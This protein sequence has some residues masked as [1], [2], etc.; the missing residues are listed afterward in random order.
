MSTCSM[1]LH[2]S[3]ICMASVAHDYIQ[4]VEI[5][6]DNQMY[7]IT[8]MSQQFLAVRVS[9]IPLMCPVHVYFRLLNY[10]ITSVS[11]VF[12]LTLT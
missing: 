11:A 5:K 10:L 3:I 2:C 8:N 7:F 4:E 1:V 9:R 6:N 12:S